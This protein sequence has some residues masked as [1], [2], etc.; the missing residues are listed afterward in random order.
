METRAYR[1]AKLFCTLGRTA[2]RCSWSTKLF[3]HD[4]TPENL[5]GSTEES[6][7]GIAIVLGSSHLRCYVR[8]CI[9]TSLLFHLEHCS[10]PQVSPLYGPTASA[11]LSGRTV[12]F[13]NTFGVLA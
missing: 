2:A 11:S 10:P 9:L 1:L 3:L 4:D 8:C 5:S 13:V 12:H 6:A 7:S